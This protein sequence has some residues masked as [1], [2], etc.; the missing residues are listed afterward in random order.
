MKSAVFFEQDGILTLPRAVQNFRAERHPNEQ[1]AINESAIIPLRELKAAGLI[2]IA[3]ANR[4]GLSTGQQSR[5]E[6]DLVHARLRR[7]F[8]LDDILICPHAPSDHC[9]CRKPRPGLFTEAAFKWH[10]NLGQSYVV[11]DKWPDA[12]AARICGC[13]SLLLE[14]PWIGA[15]HHDFVLPSLEDI[16]DKILNLM[17]TTSNRTLNLAVR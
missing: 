16:Q 15:G 9:P 10:L 4:P 11:S 5:R 1:P 8:P 14:S 7:I 13:V 17:L 2:L 6:S 12:E 3:T